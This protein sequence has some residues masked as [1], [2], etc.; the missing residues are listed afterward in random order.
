MRGL[1]FP[2]GLSGSAFISLMMGVLLPIV[3]ASA[4]TDLDPDDFSYRFVMKEVFQEPRYYVDL[5]MNGNDEELFIKSQ[6]EGTGK[7]LIIAHRWAGPIID[8]VNFLHADW[9]R[10][11]IAYDYNHDRD[12]DLFIVSREGDTLFANIVDIFHTSHSSLLQKFPIFWKPDSLE[13]LND[14]ISADICVVDRIAASN[15]EI[16]IC[17][18]HAGHS[19]WPRGIA[20]FDP[21]SG[22]KLWSYFMGTSPQ[23][24]RMADINHDNI[25]EIFV[26]SVSPDNGATTNGISDDRSYIFGFSLHGALL[27]KPREMGGVYSETDALP[28]QSQQDGKWRLYCTVA[29]GNEFT[30]GSNIT[31]VDPVTGALLGQKKIF[32]DRLIQGNSGPPTFISNGKLSLAILLTNG[33]AL[34]LDENLNTITARKFSSRI[35]S[36]TNT[37]SLLGNQAEQFGVALASGYSLIVDDHLEPMWQTDG[38]VASLALRHGSDGERTAVITIGQK[39]LLGEFE[40]NP[41]KLRRWKF[42]IGIILASSAGC[43]GVFYILSRTLPLLQLSHIISKNSSTFGIM[44]LNNKGKVYHVNEAMKGMFQTP[45]LPVHAKWENHFDPE[46]HAPFMNFI[47]TAIKRNGSKRDEPVER[48]DMLQNGHPLC[49]RVQCHP[50]HMKKFCLGWLFLVEDLTQTLQTERLVNWALVAKNLAHE[51]KTPLSTIWFTLERIRQQAEETPVNHLIEPHLASIAEEIRR[52]DNYV[53]GFMKLANVN[54]PNFQATQINEF[55]LVL[56]GAYKTKLPSSLII[57]TEFEPVIPDVDIDVH[58]FTVAVTNLLDNAVN[59]MKGQGKI[60]L[61]T[62]MAQNLSGC[63]VYISVLDSGCGISVENIPKVF[64]PYFTTSNCGSGL[65]LVITKKI[66]EDHGGSIRFISKEGIGTEFILQLPER[67][68]VG[69]SDNA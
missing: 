67:Q 3:T 33:D 8:Q 6:A 14:D 37:C 26:S 43:V 61:S 57:E 18:F 1:I 56:L 47:S 24:V 60:K 13:K 15:E 5:D 48:I 45:N 64:H 36:V 63:S 27:W 38:K 7:P 52:V 31:I 39:S 9:I 59:A 65:G 35:L 68:S 16:M 66:I 12:N 69:G 42:W 58:L 55:L 40:S 54:P 23:R 29:T 10:Y 19:L 22:R 41:L 53:K 25:P 4:Q 11:G 21:R 2:M 46:I 49:L 50:V 30:E 20:C 44:M 17:L 62:Y 51:M 34:L 28:F 32:N